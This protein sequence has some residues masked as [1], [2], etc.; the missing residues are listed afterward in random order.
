MRKKYG[1][2]AVFVVGCLFAIWGILLYPMLNRG[3]ITVSVTNQTDA[4]YTLLRINDQQVEEILE[5]DGMVD[6]DFVI[7]EAGP[8]TAYLETEAGEVLERVLT[9][10]L[11]TSVTRENYGRVLLTIKEKKGQ[12]EL[13]VIANISK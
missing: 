13:K 7:A 11:T 8:V 10:G 9:E 1:R 3:T 4:S 2:I 12:L 5:P 6:V